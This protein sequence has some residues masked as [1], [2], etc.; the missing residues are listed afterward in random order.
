[1]IPHFTP[2][3]RTPNVHRSVCGHSAA[4]VF[5]AAARV[6]LPF[7]LMAAVLLLAR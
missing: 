2:A 4:E 5:S 3:V 7:I 6:L 1:M